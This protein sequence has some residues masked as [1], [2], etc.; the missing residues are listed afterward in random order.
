MGTVDNCLTLQYLRSFGAALALLALSLGCNSEGD[1]TR[2][3]SAVQ[4]PIIRDVPKPA[5]FSLVDKNSMAR[6]SGQFRIARCEYSGGTDRSAVQ[7]FYEQNMPSAGFEL[8]HSSFDKGTVDLQFESTSEICNVRIYPSGL[9]TRI[10]VEVGPKAQ[11]TTE[12]QPPPL[13]RTANP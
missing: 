1:S 5:G 3:I 13:R 12:R 8:R 6:S 7:R 9:R 4:D 10:V 11:G 2:T